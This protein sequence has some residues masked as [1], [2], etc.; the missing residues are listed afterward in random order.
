MAIVFA[1]LTIAPKFG[2]LGICVLDKCLRV[3]ASNTKSF[4]VPQKTS[5]S[6][7]VAN[8]LQLLLQSQVKR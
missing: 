4:T 1:D 8:V 7:Y 6:I 3:L 5:I 2:P